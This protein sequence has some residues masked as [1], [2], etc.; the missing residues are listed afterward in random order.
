VRLD[1][2]RVHPDDLAR[3]D[4][5]TGEEVAGLPVEQAAMSRRTIPVPGGRISANLTNGS[6]MMRGRRRFG[7]G[8]AILPGI[9][10]P[11]EFASSVDRA[12]RLKLT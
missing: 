8:R 9:G 7:G 5:V 12:P 10:G 6:W 11:P 4:L 1:L 3:I 2:D